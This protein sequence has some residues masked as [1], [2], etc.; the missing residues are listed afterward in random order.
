MNRK[1]NASKIRK[2]QTESESLL[3]NILRTRQ[4]CGLKFRRQHPIGHYVVD[5][6][7][8]EKHLVVEIDGDYHDFTGPAD[9]AREEYLRKMGWDVIRFSAD[10][11]EEDV[12]NVAIGIAKFLQLEFQFVERK[13][14]EL[15]VKRFKES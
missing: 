5:F 10:E 13:K 15:P 8:V 1:N 4:M 2:R 3:W 6:A 7:C 11:V 12:E 9:L 14:T